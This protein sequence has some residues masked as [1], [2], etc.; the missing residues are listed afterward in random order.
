MA[1]PL[2]QNLHRLL[3]QPETLRG[4]RLPGLGL[5]DVGQPGMA[6][7]VGILLAAHDQEVLVQIVGRVE[8]DDAR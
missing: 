2:P 6:P 4:L 7:A 8:N 3:E 1:L 5:D